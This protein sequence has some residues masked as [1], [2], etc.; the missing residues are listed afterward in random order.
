M[1]IYEEKL[2]SPLALRF[3][4]EHIKTVFR[5]GHIV[6][7]TVGELEAHPSAHNDFDL[8]LQAPFP[9]IEIIRWGRDDGTGEGLHWFTLDN[10]RL[11][12]L[13]RAAMKY[14]PQRVAAK[15]EILYADPGM[16][17]KKYDSTTLGASVTVADSCKD[18][19][20]FR[21][22][23]L[24]EVEKQGGSS[25][26]FEVVARD[27]ARRE[28]DELPDAVE[29]AG[30]TLDR[31]LKAV[32]DSA[33]GG[34]RCPTPSTATPSDDSDGTPRYAQ[35]QEF[36]KIWDRKVGRQTSYP[37]D[38]DEYYAARALR[39]I[40]RQLWSHNSDGRLRIHNWSE[41]YGVQLG[42]LR[43]FIEARP[44]MYIVIPENEGKFRVDVVDAEWSSD[45]KAENTNG[46]AAGPEGSSELVRQAVAE[47]REQLG[48]QGGAG[49][50]Q[51]N[52]WNGQYAWSLGPFKSFI[53]SRSREFQV[54]PNCGKFFK[55]ALVYQ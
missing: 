33:E 6:E 1:P 36:R 7:D 51:I 17:K 41:R 20:L 5:D 48:K 8:V 21:W 27:D 11:Y 15:V 13:Q 46:C 25:I 53:R 49:Y 31:M 39:E 3:T 44:D 38:D 37:R 28:V 10:R 22:D 47:I 55:I 12:C 40:N 19:P 43:K 42:S 32:D 50:V 23:W 2:I 14:W 18:A 45:T 35:G 34:V 9:Q 16:V 26:G 4:Q 30:S 24:D 54:S 29:V 52:D